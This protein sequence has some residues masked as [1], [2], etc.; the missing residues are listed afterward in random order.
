MYFIQVCRQLSGLS[1]SLT[2]SLAINTVYQWKVQAVGTAGAGAW[3]GYVSWT[4]PAPPPAP[5]LV[6]PLAN[7]VIPDTANPSY[8]MNFTWKSVKTATSGDI[9][10]QLQVSWLTDFDPD[11]SWSADYYDST[12]GNGAIVSYESTP[13][14]V[15]W[16]NSTNYWRCAPAAIRAA[17]CGLHAQAVGHACHANLCWRRPAR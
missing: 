9:T 14:Q 15:I 8:Q 1:Y 11:Y 13:D 6:S 16:S 10:Y 17:V 2:S 12:L 5:A 3:T 7:E 4:S